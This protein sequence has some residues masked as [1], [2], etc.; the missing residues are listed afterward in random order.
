MSAVI[1]LRG[2]LG[3]DPV[4]RE[5]KN[6]KGMVTASIAVSL[7]TRESDEVQWFQLLA[8]GRTAEALGRHA[9][10]DALVDTHAKHGS[11]R[12]IEMGAMPLESF[13][14]LKAFVAATSDFGQSLRSWEHGVSGGHEACKHGDT[15]L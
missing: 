4:T 2:R 12:S 5:T 14:P 11:A 3:A 6:G 9:K 13:V 1:T 8:F 10:G 7:P 15:A